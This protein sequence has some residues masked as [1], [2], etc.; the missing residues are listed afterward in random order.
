MACGVAGR[1]MGNDRFDLARRLKQA[2]PAWMSDI[3]Q[4][5]STAPAR[6]SGATV[7]GAEANLRLPM[8][9]F[10]PRAR[11]A[12]SSTTRPFPQLKAQ[13][14]C[15]RLQQPARRAAPRHRADAAR[16]PLTRRTRSTPAASSTS[17]MSA[18]SKVRGG[19]PPRR[20]DLRQLPWRSSSAP[21]LKAGRPARWLTWIAE[22][23]AAR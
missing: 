1:G 13:N 18:A 14:R 10:A 21:R 16:H 22:E 20:A 9:V 15:R 6:N 8:D 7:V 4:S 2:V 3:H 19:H 12:P 11:W 17:I 5:G 23:R